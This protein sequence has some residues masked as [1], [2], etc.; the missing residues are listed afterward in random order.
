[1]FTWALSSSQGLATSWVSALAAAARAVG[2]GAAL[3]RVAAC[4]QS[5]SASGSFPMSQLFSSG[6][7]SIGA[8]ALVV[9]KN[10]QGWFPL[11]LTSL[12]SWL[13]KEPS[14][15]FSKATVQK[16]QFFDTQHF[17]TVLSHPYMTS[18]KTI[19]LTIWTFV[20]KVTSLLFNILSRFVIDFLPRS[21]CLAVSWL[22][23][24]STVT[25]ES[26]K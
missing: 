1:M 23:P 10:I 20:S 6:G 18:G 24:S 17:F 4:P 2:A 7:Q 14:R 21:Q 26:K 8:S 19:A 3:G 12:I 16:H 9:P 5:F 11:G 25:L 22:Q 13:S 15:V